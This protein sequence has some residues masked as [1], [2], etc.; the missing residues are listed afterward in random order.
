MNVRIRRYW[1]QPVQARRLPSSSQAAAVSVRDA[2]RRGSTVAAEQAADND[3][4][5]V[6]SSP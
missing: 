2:A 5:R 4:C 6:T 1:P 3:L